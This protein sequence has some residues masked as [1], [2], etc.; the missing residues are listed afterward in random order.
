MTQ[1]NFN[2][3]GFERFIDKNELEN[4]KNK[5]E[6]IEDSLKNDLSLKN[7]IGWSNLPF[8]YDKEEFNKILKTAK[9]V[10]ENYDAMLVLGIGGSYL[11]AKAVIEALGKDDFE[12]Y[13]AGINMSPKQINKIYNKLKNKNFCI[14]VISKSGTTTEVA[15][16]FRIFKNLLEQRF[17]KE[18]VQ[19]RIFATTDK[20]KGALRTLSEKEGYET[21]VVPDDIGGRYSVLTAVGLLPIAVAGIDVEKLILGAQRAVEESNFEFDKNNFYKYAIYRNILYSKLNKSVEVLVNYEE[22]LNYFNEWWKQL[23]GES[24][25]KEGKG[26]FP[27]SVCFTTDLHSMGQFIQ[28]GS[29]IL[30][31]T[32]INIKNYDESINIPF[33]DEDLDGLNYLQDKSLTQINQKAFEG[34]LKAH[35]DGKV[36]CSIIEIEKL[37]EISLGYLIYFFEKSCAISGMILEINPFDQPGVEHYKKNMFELLGKPGY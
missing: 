19:K 6:Q 27:A 11:G 29:N 8:D 14:N 23:F 17:S 24:E 12:I 3:E 7:Y 22:S 25:G 26:I 37:N 9:F 18:D 10:R 21:F 33:D 30:F 31:E 36:P 32:I 15:I 35:L 34:T 20:K 1:I 2:F 5:V 16:S 13:F 4:Y 28:E